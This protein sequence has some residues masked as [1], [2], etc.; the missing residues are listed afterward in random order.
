M[1][2]AYEEFTQQYPQINIK[3]D[4]IDPEITMTFTR[5]FA[6]LLPIT[7]LMIPITLLFYFQTKK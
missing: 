3:Y 5:L 1:K 6:I 7:L 4:D 2:R